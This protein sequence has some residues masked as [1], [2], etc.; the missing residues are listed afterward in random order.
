MFKDNHEKT[1]EI[2]RRVLELLFQDLFLETEIQLWKSVG[3]TVFTTATASFSSITSL[4]IPTKALLAGLLK[5]VF[6]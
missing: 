4:L 2:L 6:S 1:P 3:A 5:I